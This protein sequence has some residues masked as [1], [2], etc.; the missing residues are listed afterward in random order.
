MKKNLPKSLRVLLT[1]VVLCCCLAQSALAADFTSIVQDAT[2]EPFHN[3]IGVWSFESNSPIVVSEESGDLGEMPLGVWKCG[4]LEE[5]PDASFAAIRVKQPG[6][7][8]G[9]RLTCSNG[10]TS[11]V[12]FI[13]V[14]GGKISFYNEGFGR[15]ITY[16]EEVGMK[17]YLPEQGEN[18]I[19]L[20]DAGE[21]F[22]VDLI[23]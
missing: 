4:P 1:L 10:R 3:W 22:T 13:D 8:K 11:T 7:L 17:V 15:F 21:N 16:S 20:N 9:I 12:D 14:D 5:Q 19:S 18:V 6:D 2:T 23:T